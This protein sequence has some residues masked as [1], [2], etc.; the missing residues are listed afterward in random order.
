MVLLILC[1]LYKSYIRGKNSVPKVSAKNARIRGL[2][3]NLF[4]Y[5]SN[6]CVSSENKNVI[7]M[8]S[9]CVLIFT[10]CTCM[11]GYI[12]ELKRGKLVFFYGFAVSASALGNICNNF[13]YK[14]SEIEIVP[15]DIFSASCSSP[16]SPGK[17]IL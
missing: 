2:K 10:Q 11:H 15:F 3:A 5:R 14:L 16:L 8:C 9:C 12:L 13:A 6:L 17:Y 1:I 4:I 7:S